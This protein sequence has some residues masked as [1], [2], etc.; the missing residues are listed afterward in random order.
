MIKLEQI[1][2]LN[3]K[4]QS[5]LEVIRVLRE[6]NDLLR[7]KLEENETRVQ[8]LEVLVSTFRT[9]QDEI[10]QGI[11]GILLQ[12]DRLEDEFTAPPAPRSEV[13]E[14]TANTPSVEEEVS[15]PAQEVTAPAVAEKVVSVQEPVQQVAAPV[16][17]EIEQ[18][19]APAPEAVSSPMEVSSEPD[20]GLTSGENTPEST[21]APVETSASAVVSN[22][23]ITPTVA[24]TVPSS[25]SGETELDIF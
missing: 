2:E 8:E 19:L 17:S 20:L 24:A 23:A 6:E 10:E 1:R 13:V 18:E 21:P 5:T 3:D 16:V 4:V 14:A 12:L 15:K 22:E 25:V 11:K 7:S 9:D